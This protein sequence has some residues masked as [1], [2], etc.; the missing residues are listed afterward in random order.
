MENSYTKFQDLE[1][2]SS[3]H[4][5]LPFVGESDPFRLFPSHSLQAGNA[6]LTDR[7]AV[8]VIKSALIKEELQLHDNTLIEH[9]KIYTMYSPPSGLLRLVLI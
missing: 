7:H 5:N 8:I 4:C 2:T 6:K 9:T 3:N 1:S